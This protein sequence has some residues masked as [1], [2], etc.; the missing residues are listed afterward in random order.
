MPIGREDSIMARN[1]IAEILNARIGSTKLT[2]DGNVEIHYS[3]HL[4]AKEKSNLPDRVYFCHP[5]PTTIYFLGRGTLCSILNLD[6]SDS[7]ENCYVRIAI[8]MFDQPVAVGNIVEDKWIL[9]DGNG[10]YKI[11][12]L[13]E[14]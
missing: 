10:N 9:V 4:T 3:L 8:D 1:A 13:N 6:P 14:I 5:K 12:H 11:V 2:N 7:I